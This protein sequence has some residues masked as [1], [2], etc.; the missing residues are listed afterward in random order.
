MIR[1]LILHYYF[2]PLDSDGVP[3][4][5][6]S[7]QSE[8]QGATVAIREAPHWRAKVKRQDTPY[9]EALVSEWRSYSG[10]PD[11]LLQQLEKDLSG[12]LVRVVHHGVAAPQ[13]V[14]ESLPNAFKF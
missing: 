4:I 9:L 14:A 12:G 2:G 11:S 8:S 10:D 6:M 1:Y 7:S 13:A 5:L 3:F